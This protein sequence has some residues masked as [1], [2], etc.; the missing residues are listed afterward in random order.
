MIREQQFVEVVD[1]LVE[2]AAS[3][4]CRG[5]QLPEVG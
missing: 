4:W 3:T 2:V 1:K 5:L